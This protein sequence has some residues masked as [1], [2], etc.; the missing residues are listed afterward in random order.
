[1]DQTQLISDWAKPGVADAWNA[2]MAPAL[3]RLRN[4]PSVAMWTTGANRFGHGQ[5]QNPQVV[6]NHE[7]AWLADANWRRDAEAGLDAIRR[8]KQVDPTRP[9][10]MHAGG[11]VGDVFTANNYLCLTPLQEREEWLS[12]WAKDGDMPMLM[13]EFGTPLGA[14]FHRGRQGC[15]Q[16]EGSEPLYSEYCAIYEGADAYRS[17]TPAYRKILASQQPYGWHFTSAEQLH[18]GY[19]QLQALFLRNTWRTWRT[20][21]I[22]GGMEP[23]SSMGWQKDDGPESWRPAAIAMGLKPRPRVTLPA[24]EPGLRGDRPT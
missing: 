12:Q 21:G 19:L 22:T 16:A 3:K 14:S 10:L 7:R 8:I 23:W 11:P 18:P 1:M 6:G 4:H 9:V 13:V 20:W 2:R 17:E 5:D 15:G 24:F